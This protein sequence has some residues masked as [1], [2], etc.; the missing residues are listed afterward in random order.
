VEG[1]DVGRLVSNSILNAC[2]QSTSLGTPI[3][4]RSL[5]RQPS[6]DHKGGMYSPLNGA[7]GGIVSHPAAICVHL[8]IVGQPGQIQIHY[9]FNC[10]KS[11]C[12]GSALSTGLMDLM[13]YLEM[14][15]EVG[16]G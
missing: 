10:R 8:Q 5:Q 1:F 16:G 6:I 12:R 9:I 15:V 14:L 2:S 4:T 13:C 7:L 11:G 3:S